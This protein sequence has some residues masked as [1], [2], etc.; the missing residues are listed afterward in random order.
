MRQLTPKAIQ[1]LSLPFDTAAYF[2]F[3]REE[4]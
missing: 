2:I 3:K 1:E 4:A